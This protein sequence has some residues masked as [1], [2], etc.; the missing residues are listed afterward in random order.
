MELS[1]NQ[2]S[3][4]IVDKGIFESSSL[5]LLYL[6]FNQLT[7]EL[8]ENFAENKNLIDI[9]LQDNLFTG[10]I[11]EINDGTLENIG[12]NLFLKCLFYILVYIN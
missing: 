12:K 3:G 8:P 4:T 1:R 10:P 9:F 7:G 6:D 2:L 5:T 11:P